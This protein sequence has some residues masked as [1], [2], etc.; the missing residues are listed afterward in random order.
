MARPRKPKDQ[1][2]QRWDALYVTAAERK[3]ITAAAKAQDNSVSQYL[4]GLHKLKGT[5]RGTRDARHLVQALIAAEH[6]LSALTQ[7]V[8]TKTDPLDGL[9][10]Q[11]NL[12]AI[13]RAFRRETLPWSLAY[14][15]VD[16]E[17]S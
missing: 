12:L 17:H 8:S 2:R 14:D 6:Q 10:L 11:A 9:I 5:S 4:V 16:G 1:T 7:K 3:E 13:E 15:H